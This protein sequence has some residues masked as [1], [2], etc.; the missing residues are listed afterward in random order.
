MATSDDGNIQIE[1]LD[2]SP[3]PEVESKHSFSQITLDKG[4][5]THFGTMVEVATQTEA[6]PSIPPQLQTVVESADSLND[7]NFR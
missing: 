6:L 1:N 5:Q 2:K 3:R 7:L 4:V